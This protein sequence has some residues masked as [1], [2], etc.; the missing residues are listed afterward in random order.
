M[1]KVLFFAGG[2][3]LTS[4]AILPLKTSAAPYNFLEDFE[5]QAPLT[6]PNSVEYT[7][8]KTASDVTG[9]VAIDTAIGARSLRHNSNGTVLDSHYNSNLEFSSSA[10]NLCQGGS[11]RFSLFLS[12]LPTSI[13]VVWWI[14]LTP[15]VSPPISTESGGAAGSGPS[16]TALV[17]S[18]AAG[19]NAGGYIVS[20]LN[21][22]AS[23]GSGA[24]RLEPLVWYNF[25]ITSV[26]CTAGNFVL[27]RN[28]TAIF[29]TNNVGDLG[30]SVLDNFQIGH[31]G[32]ADGGTGPQLRLDNI[33]WIDTEG[34]TPG[35]LNTVAVTNLIGFDASGDGST[36]IAKVNNGDNVTTYSGTGLSLLGSSETDCI[37]SDGVFTNGP[38]V[39]FF[40]CAGSSDP[41]HSSLLVIGSRNMTT[42]TFSSCTYCNPLIPL[43]G[44]SPVLGFDEQFDLHGQQ[45]LGTLAYPIDYSRD[46]FFG[47]NAKWVVW[48]FSS[49]QGYIGVALLT[50][51]EDGDEETRVTKVQFGGDT[52]TQVCVEP[53]DLTTMYMAAVDSGVS[54]KIYRVNFNPS[55]PT[56]ILTATISAST[57][58]GFPGADSVACGRNRV[59]M[60]RN[61]AGN[62]GEIEI[63]GFNRSS[64]A[65]EW[66]FRRDTGNPF[67]TANRVLTMSANSRWGAFATD[68]DFTIFN[69]S[70]GA[71]VGEI[72]LPIGSFVGLDMDNVGAVGWAATDDNI[73]VY[74]LTNVTCASDNSCVNNEDCVILSFQC[75]FTNPDLVPTTGVPTISTGAGNPFQESRAVS[76]AALGFDTGWLIGIGMIVLIAFAVTSKLGT[77]ITI[78][79]FAIFIAIACAAALLGSPWTWILLVTLFIIIGLAGMSLFSGRDEGGAE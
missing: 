20:D 39:S 19:N 61:V 16:F 69:A 70:S 35:I 72:P 56:G 60:A 8:S 24:F 7:Y 22:Q 74:D 78:L 54:P 1:K 76:S 32:N 45:L 15:S 48:P 66:T 2:L 42:P 13:N 75:Q 79:T 67:Y 10:P 38:Y 43:E 23:G 18:S 17:I 41:A 27:Y 59:I 3:L 44:I 28:D 64:G 30:T 77:S 47:Q 4:F 5:S 57:S 11:L 73:A 37:D 49:F 63:A 12:S 68:T 6:E 71:I 53:Y 52:P 55:G 21:N 51:Q 34:G 25:T 26:D 14:G 65:L 50:M 36:V 33:Q 40:T 58:P 46:N 29:A 31:R 9:H 62:L